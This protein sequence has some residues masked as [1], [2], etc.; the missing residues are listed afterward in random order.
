MSPRV[1]NNP[2]NVWPFILRV[3]PAFQATSGSPHN[4]IGRADLRRQKKL[5]KWVPCF[6]YFIRRPYN[7]P[8]DGCT[9]T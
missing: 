5:Q 8:G 6:A 9:G 3:I 4:S 1:Q 7:K 2:Y